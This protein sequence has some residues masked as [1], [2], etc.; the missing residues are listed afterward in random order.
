V[1]SEVDLSTFV[2]A[3]RDGALVIDVRELGEYA[4]GHVPGAVPIPMGEVAAR[5]GEL[6]RGVP[7]YLIC[8]SGNRSLAA[9]D[10][11]VRVGVDARSVAGGTTAWARTGHPVTRGTRATA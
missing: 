1:R 11:L 7:V 2:A 8:A 10:Y 9:A 3:H 4:D 5:A 6:P